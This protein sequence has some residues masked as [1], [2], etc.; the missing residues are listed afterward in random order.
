MIR[1]FPDSGS[2]EDNPHQ[3]RVPTLAG[4]LK[5]N[6]PFT[7]AD[8]YRCGVDLGG[9]LTAPPAASSSKHGYSSVE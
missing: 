5:Q 3:R 2:G 6:H 8:F 1:T 4:H 7:G 9:S